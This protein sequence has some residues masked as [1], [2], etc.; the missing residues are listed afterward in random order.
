VRL[1]TDAVKATVVDVLYADR[2]LG[3][4]SVLYRSQSSSRFFEIRAGISGKQLYT[5]RKAIISGS[6]R[7]LYLNINKKGFFEG[8]KTSYRCNSFR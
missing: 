1:T 8:K 3:S 5:L 7:H 2:N 6:P 4:F